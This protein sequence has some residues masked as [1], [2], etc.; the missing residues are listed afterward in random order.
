MNMNMNMNMKFLNGMDKYL[1]GTCTWN[2]LGKWYMV[3]I[4]DWHGHGAMIVLD[5]W[6]TQEIHDV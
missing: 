2:Y 1:H 5:I 4:W 6:F 3:I